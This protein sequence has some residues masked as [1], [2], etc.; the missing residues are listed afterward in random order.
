MRPASKIGRPACPVSE[1]TLNGELKAR[2]EGRYLDIGE[3]GL[4]QA[5][6]P[7]VRTA[8]VVRK[9]HNAGGKS[10]WM[11]GFWDKP[12]PPLWQN[13]RLRKWRE[14]KVRPIQGSAPHDPAG[15]PRSFFTS[16]KERLRQS[17]LRH[18]V[19]ATANNTGDA[20]IAFFKA[21]RNLPVRCRVVIKPKLKREPLP[22]AGSSRP[23][24]ETRGA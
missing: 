15:K 2:Y 1:L 22:P 14:G 24:P 5:A 8:K 9:D 4:P 23:K 13:T 6:A 17:L 3:C 12:T 20:Q 21:S 10:R 16:L 7:K 11:D 19:T 18:L